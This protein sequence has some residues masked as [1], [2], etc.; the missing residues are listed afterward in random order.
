M[1]A[2]LSDL[3]ADV[4]EKTDPAT[5]KADT[6]PGWQKELDAWTATLVEPKWAPLNAP[7]KK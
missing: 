3:S 6:A 1:P 5:T 4:S 2:E 7:P